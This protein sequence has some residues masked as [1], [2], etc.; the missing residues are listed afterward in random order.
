M[1]AAETAYRMASVKGCTCASQER[2]PVRT[3]PQIA[4]LADGWRAVVPRHLKRDV[5]AD[6]VTPASPLM[7][8]LKPSDRRWLQ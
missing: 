8:C 7:G 5:K 4:A 2:A 6:S 1:R 3:D